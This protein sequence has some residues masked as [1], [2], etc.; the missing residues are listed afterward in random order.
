[1]NL[2]RQ[3]TREL[4]DRLRA[5]WPDHSASKIANILDRTRNAIIGKA[6][7]M[8]LDC[9]QR[10]PERKP[11]LPKAFRTRPPRKP[12][13]APDFSE[14]D[15]G[16]EPKSLNV[17]FRRLKAAQCR[18]PYGLEA[19]YLFCGHPIEAPSSYCAYHRRV[20]Q[21]RPAT[22]RLKAGAP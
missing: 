19:P 2:D 13:R 18:Y 5:L 20:C 8:H 4:T 15:P 22:V 10:V 17:K 12:D 16:M 9:K 1:M 7:R 21:V 11:R 3:W 6:H 14:L